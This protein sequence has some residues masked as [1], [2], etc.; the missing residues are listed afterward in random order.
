MALLLAGPA[1]GQIKLGPKPGSKAA[2]A[3]AAVLTGRIRHPTATTVV[4]DYGTN[5]LSGEETHHLTARLSPTGEFRLAVPAA[6]LGEVSLSHGAEYTPLYLTRGDA[7]RLTLDARQLDATVSYTGRGAAPSNY[8]AEHLRRF[9]AGARYEQLPEAQADKA[10]PEH[11]QA[12][13][14][15]HRRQQAAFLDSFAHRQPLPLAFRAYARRAIAYGWTRD[16]QQYPAVQR[17][18]RPLGAPAV[19]LPAGYFDFQQQ[20]PLANDAALANVQYRGYLAGYLHQTGLGDSLQAGARPFAAVTRRLGTGRSADYAIGQLLYDQLEKGT[21]E[22]GALLPA[23]QQFSHNSAL[24]RTVR[25]R[26]RRLLPLQPGRPA[27]D[28]TLRDEAD[29]PV[30]LRDFRGQVVY[31]DFWASWCGPCVAEAPAT[32]RLRQQFAGRDV[33]FLAVSIDQQPAAWR[34]ALDHLNLRA[35]NARHLIDPHHF[36]AATLRAY[37][38]QGVPTYWLIGREGQIIKGNAPRPSEEAD[39]TAALEGALKR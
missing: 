39:V 9:E 33:V 8:L 5:W 35:P 28:F 3:P 2:P 26:Y 36:D 18:S 19:P 27:P 24:V 20:V 4:L 13:A 7:V 38:A 37:E 25:T 14:A 15:A 10:T 30:S 23:Y 32:A 6:A 11:F 31:L 12:L 21:A 34:K 17:F 22:V 1:T 16:L 29:K